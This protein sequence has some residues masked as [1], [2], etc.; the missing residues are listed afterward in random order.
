[1][2]PLTNN[3]AENE[4]EQQLPTTSEF[5]A[6]GIDLLGLETYE[7]FVEISDDNEYPGICGD[8]EGAILELPSS[9]FDGTTPA[10][11]AYMTIAHELIHATQ[12]MDGILD[13]AECTWMGESFVGVPY[14]EQG[15][16]VEAYDGEL[17]LAKEILESIA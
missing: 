12:L 10:V 16:E 7:L 6:A 5:I 8:S 15:H 13:L 1:M 2:T 11:D 3:R 4:M 9:F 14:E 17:E